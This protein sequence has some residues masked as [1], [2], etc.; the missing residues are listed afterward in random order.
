MVERVFDRLL[1]QALRFGGRKPILGLPLEFRFADE[2]RKQSAGADHDIVAGDS[3]SAFA[4]ADAVGV[5]FEPARQCG[6]RPNSW[7]PPSGVGMVLQ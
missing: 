1:D 5:I 4:L 6:A 2:H 3:G 7:V